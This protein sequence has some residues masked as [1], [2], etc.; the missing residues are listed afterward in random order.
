MS[1]GYGGSGESLTYESEADFNTSI[2]QRVQFTL[3]NYDASE[4]SGFDG[5]E[6]QIN[7][8]GDVYDFVFDTLSGAEGFFTNN[9]LSL[10]SGDEQFIDVSYWL[11]AD[12]AGY[13]LRL[14]LQSGGP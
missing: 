9:T 10:A 14:H 3:L 11:T 12:R 2:G 4:A 13:R 8:G 7:V 6:L 5:L 1:A